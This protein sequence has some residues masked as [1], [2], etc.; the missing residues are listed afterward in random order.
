M[1]DE[2]GRKAPSPPS[3]AQGCEPSVSSVNLAG[4][5]CAPGRTQGQG[6]PA[7]S[8]PWTGGALAVHT[9]TASATAAETAR[10][11]GADFFAPE[12]FAAEVGAKGFTGFADHVAR[13]WGC[14]RG[15]VFFAACG[16]VVRAMAPLLRDKAV[17]PA[18]VAADPAGRFV[19][20]LLS[21]HLGGANDLARL[22]ASLTGG[23]AV[24]TTATDAMGAPAAEVLAARLGLGLE[25][26]AAL[27]AVNAV[28]AAG[29]TVAVFDPWRRFEVADPGQ[30]RFFEWVSD[31]SMLDPARPHIVVDVREAAPLP[32]RLAL[33][34]RVLAVGLGCRRGTSGE[35]IVAAVRRVLEARGLSASCVGIVAT[36][37]IKRDEPGLLRAA[38][39]F[40]AETMFY[41]EGEL[42][43]VAVPTPS[44]TVKRRVGTKSVCEAAA[45]LAAGTDRLVVKKTV[46]G[47]VTVAVAMAD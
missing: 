47:P 37:G 40:S 29:G 2:P 33:R 14:Y 9:L 20:S 44:Q 21:G 22:A 39:E 17:D 19:V 16:A 31:P 15:H 24:V 10:R 45:M 27:V 18:V 35:V 11:L 12:R 26:R 34:P 46:I 25:N 36:A 32:A 43:A 4:P 41:P 3:R 13:V 23:Q 8:G 7:A 28:L 6:L 1:N 38:Q 42:D 30:A 5:P